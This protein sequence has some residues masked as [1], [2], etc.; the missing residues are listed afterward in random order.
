MT[1]ELAAVVFGLSSAL[2][3]GAG[4]FSGGLA[5]RKQP[6]VL[7]VLIAQLIGTSLLIVAALA[8]GEAFPPSDDIGIAAV[9]GAFGGLGLL[10]LYRAMSH[11]NIGVVAPVSGL[12]SALVPSVYGFFIDGAPDAQTLIGFGLAFAAVWL[13]S[14]GAGAEHLSPRA[15]AEP[16]LAGAAFGLYLIFLNQA[17]TDAVVWPVI[18]G[19]FASIALIALAAWRTRALRL[20]KRS[21]LPLMAGAGIFD[22]LGNTLFALAAQVGRLD[23]A[24]VLS[25]L[26]PAS[27]VSLA[28]IFLKERLGRMQWVGVGLALV[29]ILLIA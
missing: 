24:S 27:T 16:A 23:V 29:A 22:S 1:P 7:V 21:D 13:I 28:A 12:T 20:P 11:G 10:L 9:A 5:S 8:L 4:D 14:G 19:R 3:W 18:I 17:T 26:Y 25:S 6:A 15:L 2:F